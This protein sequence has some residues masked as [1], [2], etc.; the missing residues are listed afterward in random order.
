M[1]RQDGSVM[2][3]WREE[4]SPLKIGAL[5]YVVMV[6]TEAGTRVMM[7]ILQM[8]MG[9]TETVSLKMDGNVQVDLLRVLT[10]AQSCVEM[11]R[12]MVILNVMMET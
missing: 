12:M 10:P 1:L 11:P 5:R 3:V 2:V 4:I 6:S 8:V 7:V 9:V